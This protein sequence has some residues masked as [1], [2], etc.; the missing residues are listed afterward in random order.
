MG[1]DSPSYAIIVYDMA[2]VYAQKGELD[3]ALE[4]IEVPRAVYKVS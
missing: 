1:K 4:M 2:W 3:H